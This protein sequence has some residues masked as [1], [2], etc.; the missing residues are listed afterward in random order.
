[1]VCIGPAGCAPGRGVEARGGL[2]G[3][4]R[5]GQREPRHDLGPLPSGA[6]HSSISVPA[7]RGRWFSD[8]SDRLDVRKRCWVWH[9]FA[10]PWSR[11]CHLSLVPH[12]AP[13]LHPC[14]RRK[15]LR[16]DA[17]PASPRGLSSQI[18]NLWENSSYWSQWGFSDLSSAMQ[19]KLEQP[20]SS[21]ASRL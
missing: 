20:P 16:G 19:K 13:S 5:R 6:G 17:A 10:C 3:S 12:L 9:G 8:S 15:G 7:V 1:V 11:R 18:P 4:V 21:P 14:Q 2:N